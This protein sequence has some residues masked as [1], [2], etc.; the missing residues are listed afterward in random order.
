MESHRTRSAG[1]IVLGDSG[2]IALVKKRDRERWGFPKGHV[3]L[4][5][6]DEEAA[7]REIEEETGLTNLEYLDD[8]G[9]YERYRIN[10]DGTYDESEYKDIHLLL[11]AAQ[12]H[13]TLAPQE[14]HEEAKWVPLQGLITELGEK[15]GAWFSTVFPRVREAIQRD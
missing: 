1:G 10:A 3:E 2:T 14:A 6:T 8:L 13:A 7:R 15:E 11:F 9:S 5:E 4:G 12:P